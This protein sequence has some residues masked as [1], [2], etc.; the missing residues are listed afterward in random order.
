LGDLFEICQAIALERDYLLGGIS[1]MP[2]H[3]HMCLRGALED[4]P[5]AIAIAYMNESCRKLGVVGLWRP[6]YYVGT[7][8]AYN[9]NAVRGHTPL[10]SDDKPVWE[11][12]REPDWEPE[13]LA[14]RLG[15]QTRQARLGAGPGARVPSYTPWASDGESP[16]G[17]RSGQ[18]RREVPQA[19]LAFVVPISAE[20]GLRCGEEGPA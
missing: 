2:D 3:L 12:D 20:S 4:S 14:T 13:F 5:E 1:V 10:A 18:A 6:S 9:M 15:L 16:S 19:L 17:S 7:T 11:P 8:G